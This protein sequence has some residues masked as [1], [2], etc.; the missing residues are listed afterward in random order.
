MLPYVSAWYFAIHE[1]SILMYE[2]QML[3][4]KN[5]GQITCFTHLFKM[6]KILFCLMQ[7]QL[8]L[9]TT[10]LLKMSVVFC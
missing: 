7:K 9:K 4:H 1:H 10:S 3:Q 8:F 5:L 6:F 2:Y